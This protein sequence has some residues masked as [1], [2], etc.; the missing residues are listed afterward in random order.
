MEDENNLAD[1]TTN[2]K[3][4]DGAPASTDITPENTSNSDVEET[5]DNEQQKAEQENANS[6]KEADNID[7]T[8]AFSKRLKEEIEK[9]RQ[10][11]MAEVQS[12]NDKLAQAYNF[13]NYKEFEEYTEKQKLAQVGI[14][15]EE[16]FNDILN[17]KIEKNPT[18][19]KAKEIILENEQERGKQLLIKE[20]KEINKIDPSI[21]TIDD[22]VKMDNIDEFNNLFQK[23][24]YSMLDAYKIANFDKLSNKASAKA[25][26][27][28]LNNLDSKSHLKTNSGS[29]G[30]DVVIPADVLEQFT[31]SG[32]TKEEA[33][34]YYIKFHEE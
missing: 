2:E 24:H 4:V 30:N 11:I 33:Q 18:V 25:K 23:K 20:L 28:V 34:K 22:L 19:L 1:N 16:M 15:D 13:K 26:Q 32:M 9:A 12:K 21:N 14:Q 8:K 3:F 5:E 7:V 17:E 6:P 29:S 31:N 10:E 27:E